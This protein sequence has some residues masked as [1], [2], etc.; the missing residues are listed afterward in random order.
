MS[1]NIVQLLMDRDGLDFSEAVEIAEE[2]Y[3]VADDWDSLVTA[4]KKHNIDP[5]ELGFV[6]SHLDFL[7]ENDDGR[8]ESL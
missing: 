8:E 5:V 7:L 2:V 1:S 6:G 4:L 3:A